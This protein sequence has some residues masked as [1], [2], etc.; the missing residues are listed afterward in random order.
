MRKR[1]VSD[2]N[3]GK[4]IVDRNFVKEV[5]E[6]SNNL[7]IPWYLGLIDT[8]LGIVIGLMYVTQAETGNDGASTEQV[9]N[10]GQ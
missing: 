7:P 6:I 10:E 3:L 1:A 5:D 2:F 8:M 9:V 4:D